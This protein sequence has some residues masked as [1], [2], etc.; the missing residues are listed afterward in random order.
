MK[1][2]WRLQSVCPSIRL[3]LSHAPSPKR[4]IEQLWLL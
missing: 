1:Q 3:C 4:C 2:S